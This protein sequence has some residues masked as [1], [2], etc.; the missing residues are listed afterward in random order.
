MRVPLTPLIKPYYKR[1]KD[2]YFI[3]KHKLGY[4][5]TDMKEKGCSSC[6]TRV[7]SCSQWIAC[8]GIVVGKEQGSFYLELWLFSQSKGVMR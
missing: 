2:I 8:K 6:A 7:R 1:F 4:T 5:L 3:L